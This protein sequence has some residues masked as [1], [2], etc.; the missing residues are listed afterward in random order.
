MHK[1]QF[2]AAVPIFVLVL[3]FFLVAF[4]TYVLYKK[5]R[6]RLT[7]S[8]LFTLVGLRS[9]IFVVFICLLCEPVFRIFTSEKQTQTLTVLSD[10]SNS[11]KP[12][13]DTYTKVEANLQSFANLKQLPFQIQTFNSGDKSNFTD[14]ST[15]LNAV[16]NNSAADIV[17]LLSDGN[18]N[19]SNNRANRLHPFH[20]FAL[21]IGRQMPRN[22]ARIQKIDVPKQILS[23]SELAVIPIHIYANNVTTDLSLTVFINDKRI[24][25]KQL[26]KPNGDLSTSF[27]FRSSN[28]DSIFS[29][30]AVLNSLKPDEKTVVVRKNKVDRKIYYLS[31]APNLNAKYIHLILAKNGYETVFF[32][33]KDIPD[34]LQLAK[35]SLFIGA[36][37][38]NLNTQQLNT[39]ETWLKNSSTPYV[40]TG[41][42]PTKLEKLGIHGL[43]LQPQKQTRLETGVRSSF[44]ST[45]NRNF[46]MST[47][48]R[49]PTLISQPVSLDLETSF[50]SVDLLKSMITVIKKDQQPTGLLVTSTDFWKTHLSTSN[51]LELQDFFQSFVLA[52]ASY[53][54]TSPNDYIKIITPQDIFYT[55]VIYPISI[56]AQDATSHPLQFDKLQFK[57]SL[58]NVIISEKEFEQ[59]SIGKFSA[60][61]NPLKAGR[62]KLTAETVSTNKVQLSK[63]LFI[64]VEENQLELSEPYVNKAYFRSINAILMDTLQ[65]TEI[66]KH[67]TAEPHA[68]IKQH[69][70]YP[71][72]SKQL[73]YL[74]LFLIIVEWTLRKQFKLL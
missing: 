35:P 28:S 49:L 70:L 55:N 2:D 22:V 48:S 71:I 46:P 31:T 65:L 56:V 23:E 60:L 13:L 26:A 7:K 42:L 72:N 27:T 18:Q 21:P 30:R 67:V 8:R 57:V 74:L 63:H 47:L 24:G 15:A 53:L 34:L 43:K 38:A 39:L 59:N 69:P 37:I 25:E 6:P 68:I 17:V 73:L 52:T 12:Y 11:A 40:L 14:I 36:E 64:I 1:I 29:I 41:N 19:V 4:A 20:L 16:A 50:S 9:I 45:F 51:D 62:Y 58:N 61:F 5:T 44:F 32:N 3:L 33:E 54:Q 10:R 66:E